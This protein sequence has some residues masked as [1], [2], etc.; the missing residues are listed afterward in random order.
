[1]H[2]SC[3]DPKPCKGLGDTL[4]ADPHAMVQQVQNQLNAFMILAAGLWCLLAL[5][6]MLLQELGSPASIVSVWGWAV[7]VTQI[8]LM[9]SP[10]SGLI[11]AFE[12][13]S[14]ASFHLGVC[15][16]NLASSSMWT[17]Y[18]VV[19][20][21][22]LYRQRHLAAIKSGTAVHDQADA[23]TLACPRL[24]TIRSLLLG[25]PSALGALLSAAALLVRCEATPLQAC[26]AD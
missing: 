3:M 20:R 19:W 4:Q 26:T 14:S 24:Q 23:L 17:L 13:R 1:M 12:T 5:A 25:I 15:S 8:L 18:S 11:K 16:M 6:T 22:H 2:A 7:S 21:S 9:A 10:L